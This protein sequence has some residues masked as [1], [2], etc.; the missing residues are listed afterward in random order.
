MK[1]N[2]VIFHKN[3]FDG[4]SSFILLH[5]KKL[6][7][8]DAIIFPDYPSSK[9]I[10]INIADKNI[11]IV[12]VAYNI[13]VIKEI[14][15]LAKSVLFIDHHD[16]IHNDV[17]SI[18]NSKFKYIYDIN[19]CG[20]SLVWKTFYV[21]SSPLFIKYIRDNDIGLWKMKYS[22][23][24]II[25][26]GVKYELTLKPNVIK[27]WNNL[28]SVKYVNKLITIGLVYS[29]YNEYLCSEYFS[30]YSLVSFPSDLIYNKYTD[31]FKKPAQYKV[32]IYNG[33]CPNI[34]ALSVYALSKIDC[35]FVLFWNYNFDKKETIISMRSQNNMDVGAIAKLF[36][37]GGHINAAACS[38]NFD[39]KDLFFSM[40]LPRN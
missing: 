39:I 26:L 21:G 13:S 37:G 12:D 23:E 36:G 19:E 27:K 29:E 40:T 22:K 3:C 34:T 1:F 6:I 18:D 5:K 10:P 32:C 20:A 30:R 15:A 4:Y 25:A 38:I 8:H 28:F 16:S 7:D 35:D 33:A 2:Y 9:N 24:F 17:L 11:I 31:F 14:I